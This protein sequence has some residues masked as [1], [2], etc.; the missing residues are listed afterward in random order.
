MHGEVGEEDD[1]ALLHAYD[2]A[3]V[4]FVSAGD[5]FHVV[6]HAEVFLQLL[7]W[8]LQGVLRAGQMKTGAAMRG[9][10]SPILEDPQ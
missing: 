5:H 10:A 9:K 1:K 2:E 3:R 4:A 6:A 7:S 8:E